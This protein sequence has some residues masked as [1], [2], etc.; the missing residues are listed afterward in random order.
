MADDDF[1]QALRRHYL[2]L[3]NRM[4]REERGSKLYW[5]LE[6]AI[7]A[8]ERLHLEAFKEPIISVHSTPGRGR[9]EEGY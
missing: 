6:K 8:T 4:D 7:F 2:D 1:R 3:R 5:A 9:T